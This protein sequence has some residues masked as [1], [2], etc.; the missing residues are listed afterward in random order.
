M[1]KATV[2][3]NL[4]PAPAAAQ[5]SSAR[6]LQRNFLYKKHQKNDAVNH[7]DN[8]HISFLFNTMHQQD[9]TKT[10][11]NSKKH[12]NRGFSHPGRIAL[13]IN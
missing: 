5:E 8:P 11:R 4:F 10:T 1:L 3:P 9:P 13:I 6:L 12:Q 2:F 7:R